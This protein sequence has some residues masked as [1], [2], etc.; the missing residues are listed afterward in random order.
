MIRYLLLPLLVL[1]ACYY[2][3]HETC[4]DQNGYEIECKFRGSDGIDGINGKDGWGVFSVY[5][6]RTR[7]GWLYG[8]NEYGY[9]VWDNANNLIF[10]INATT[11]YVWGDTVEDAGVYTKSGCNGALSLLGSAY[12]EPE[13]LLRRIYTEHNTHGYTRSG[14]LYAKSGQSYSPILM[15][16]KVGGSCFDYT[17][18]PTFVFDVE[19][20]ALQNDFPLPITITEY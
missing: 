16:K 18:R 13:P 14:L 11:G 5:S 1:P 3:D 8:V 7:L 15:G 10:N 20:V 17:I 4:Y 12:L 19:L 6:N 9:E 2:Y